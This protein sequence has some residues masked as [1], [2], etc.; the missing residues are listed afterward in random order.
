MNG[1]F[2]AADIDKATR[3]LERCRLTYRREQVVLRRIGRAVIKQAKKNVR[4]QKSV[5]GQAFAPRLKKRKGRR[6]MLPNLAKKLRSKNEAN[7][8][9]VGFNN[10]LTGRIAHTQQHGTPSETWT[11]KRMTKVRG[12]YQH[13]DKPPTPR[14]ARML[15]KAGFTLKK[16]R[17]EGRKRPTS[18][19]VIANL[20]QGKLFAIWRELTGHE[21]SHRW[22]INNAPRAFLGLTRQQSDQIITR[23]VLR[24]ME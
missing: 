21:A 20:T 19:W 12:H 9:D 14:Q 6:K 22:E 10:R 15:I 13:Y 16:K 5:N 3:A 24:E 2:S 11:G 17:G 4:E 8:V 23:E 1:E 18:K 7:R